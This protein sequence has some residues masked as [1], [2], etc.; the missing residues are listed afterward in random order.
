MPA[1][2]A[3]THFASISSMKDSFSGSSFGVTPFLFP[4]PGLETIRAIGWA[5]S[6]TESA[7][8]H[9]FV[10]GRHIP[11]PGDLDVLEEAPPEPKTDGGQLL[12]IPIVEEHLVL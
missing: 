6:P 9:G 8:S 12:L 11:S 7:G 2:T 4:P 1:P 10:S 5:D 3:L